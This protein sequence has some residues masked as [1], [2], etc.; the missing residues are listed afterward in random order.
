MLRDAIIRKTIENALDEDIGSG[1]VTTAS[2]LTG[3]ETG[4]AVA[5]AKGTMTVAG[6]D[7]FKEVFL[8][9]D[10]NAR[11]D[12]STVDGQEASPGE[13][14]LEISGS[15]SNILT[16][17]RTA[18]NLFQRMCGI[19]TL[20]RQYVEEIKG[21]RARILDTRKTMPGLRMLD[22]YAVRVG[23]GF[24][25]R[26][27]LYD[28]IL[29]KENHVEA[30]GGIS[31]AVE[32]ARKGVPHT[33][34]IEVETR[35]VEE[36]KEAVSCGVDIIMLDNMNLDEMKKAVD[37]IKGKA[38]VEASGNVRLNTVRKIAECGVDYI[39]VGAITHSAP[40]SDISLLV[41]PRK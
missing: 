38:L 36:V 6:I 8:I 15:L 24:N 18:L 32:R 2:I 25:H 35:N 3:E 39:S 37:L 31:A 41:K 14:L 12:Q 34:K 33:L 30:A 1:D 5:V 27:G 9:G 20:V 7:I 11:F 40:A 10:P 17:E 4:V 21:T 19:A 26:I 23:G 28:G 13:V 22:K 29:I 16:A